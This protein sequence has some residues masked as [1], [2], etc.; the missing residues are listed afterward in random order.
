MTHMFLTPPPPERLPA[1]AW[2][3][4]LKPTYKGQPPGELVIRAD[5]LEAIMQLGLIFKVGGEHVV[6]VVPFGSFAR[7]TAIDPNTGQCLH[8]V[9]DTFGNQTGDDE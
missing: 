3:V 9:L 7:A 2:R 5:R 4:H 8:S 6:E 1:R